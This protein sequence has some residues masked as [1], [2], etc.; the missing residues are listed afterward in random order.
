M[1]LT[2][3]RMIDPCE[4][5][6]LRIAHP[7]LLNRKSQLYTYV[8]PKGDNQQLDHIMNRTKWWKSITSCRTYNTIYIGSDNILLNA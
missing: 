1:R 6:D 5:T 2:K 7:H 3:N 4:A 8:G